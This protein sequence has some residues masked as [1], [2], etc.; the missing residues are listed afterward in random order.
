VASS[1]VH[2]EAPTTN[3]RSRLDTVT[4]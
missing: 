1:E 3:T 4:W 2:N